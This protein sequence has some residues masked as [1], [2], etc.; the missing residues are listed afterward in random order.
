MKDSRGHGSNTRGASMLTPA[1]RGIMPSRPFRQ[2]SQITS[3]PPAPGSNGGIEHQASI[4]EQHGVSTGHL[5]GEGIP[6]NGY[7]TGRYVQSGG[8]SVWQPNVEFGK[9]R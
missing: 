4:A 8:R 7:K 3:G 9:R 5:Q 2:S 6:F 1:G